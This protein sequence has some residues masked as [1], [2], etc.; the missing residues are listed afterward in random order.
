MLLLKDKK[1]QQ[2]KI[3]NC[4]LGVQKY[5]ILIREMNLNKV[6]K[7]QQLIY[8]RFLLFNIKRIIVCFQL[9]FNFLRIKNVLIKC[10]SNLFFSIVKLCSKNHS[11]KPNKKEKHCYIYQE[12]IQSLINS[13]VMDSQKTNILSQIFSNSS[14]QV[15]EV[16]AYNLIKIETLIQEPKMKDFCQNLLQQ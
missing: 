2:N 12:Q 3:M 4:F 6:S 9:G 15:I 16:L 8:Q 14:H 11:Q 13:K 5:G 10:K 1:L 7:T